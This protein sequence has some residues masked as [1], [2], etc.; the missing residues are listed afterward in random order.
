MSTLKLD[1][2]ALKVVTFAVRDD[3]SVR[4]PDALGRRETMPCSV[5][6]SYCQIECGTETISYDG[7]CGSN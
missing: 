2:Q 1:V 3:A 4:A 7:G 6:P 5:Y